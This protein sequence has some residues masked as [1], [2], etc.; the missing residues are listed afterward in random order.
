M[1]RMS[2]RSGLLNYIPS[3]I[4]A[5]Q[6]TQSLQDQHSP[7]QHRYPADLP[8]AVPNA[9]QTFES[10]PATSSVPTR[11]FQR[12]D[13]PSQCQLIQ[14]PS[15]YYTTAQFANTNASLSNSRRSYPQAQPQMPPHNPKIDED[16]QNPAHGHPIQY[17]GAPTGAPLSTSEPTTKEKDGLLFD[18]L[19]DSTAI[20]EHLFR[21]TLREFP[22]D[23][24]DDVERHKRQ[25]VLSIVNA[26]KHKGFLPPPQTKR[27]TNNALKGGK[28][29]KQQA[30]VPTTNYERVMWQEWQESAQ[31][32]VDVHLNQDG[33]NE[34]A[35]FHAW[36]VCEEMIKTHRVGYR[37][38]EQRKDAK[39]KCSVR[40]GEA[41]R[42]I[43]EY[44]IV[45][46]KLLKNDKIPNFC[47]SPQAYANVTIYAHKNNSNRNKPADGDAEVPERTTTHRTVTMDGSVARR[48]KARPGRSAKQDKES[49]KTKGDTAVE[50]ADDSEQG[51]STAVPGGSRADASVARYGEEEEDEG[52][53][54][55]DA[56]GEADDVVDQE[57]AKGDPETPRVSARG[58]LRGLPATN[59]DEDV[60]IPLHQDLLEPFDEDDSDLAHFDNASTSTATFQT[61]THTN[62]RGLG[63]PGRF[64]QDHSTPT[65]NDAML[66]S[67]R[68]R[69][70]LA[71]DAGLSQPAVYAPPGL[72]SAMAPSAGY[73]ASTTDQATTFPSSGLRNIHD[74]Q[75]DVRKTRTNKRRKL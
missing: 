50:S 28:K 56:E 14:A 20:T 54:D 8:V 36:T 27:T 74:P 23:D 42:V 1:S 39:M 46:D 6:D 59:L 11:Q 3:V 71:M 9:Y 65:A 10:E 66:S 21:T 38:T 63:A 57:D 22:N 16:D 2:V 24:V 49:S 70:S 18:S 45:R 12:Q 58:S 67:S 35:E 60:L 5:G 69:D 62:M 68:S 43:K 15:T 31:K 19:E 17:A 72:P 51:S 4:A 33:S 37:F 7:E 64:A 53:E 41:V 29:T 32:S 13:Q 44:A 40:I 25:H 47:I 73:P 34:S 30:T 48:F 26:L 52:A 61:L 75:K 55:D